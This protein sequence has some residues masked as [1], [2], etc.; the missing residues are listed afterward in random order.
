MIIKQV[1]HDGA[2]TYL[3]TPES[4]EERAAMAELALSIDL[5]KRISAMC[6]MIE[7]I[8]TNGNN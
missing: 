1:H 6:E 4:D 2:I 3:R 7:R 5:E 8:M